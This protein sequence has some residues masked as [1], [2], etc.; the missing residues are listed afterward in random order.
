MQS[1]LYLPRIITELG[2]DLHNNVSIVLF[3]FI[4]TAMVCE[5]IQP[6]RLNAEGFSPS[7]L[8]RGLSVSATPGIPT[9]P[10]EK[11]LNDAKAA[12]EASDIRVLRIMVGWHDTEGYASLTL[13]YEPLASLGHST[14]QVVLRLSAA[15]SK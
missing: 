6:E 10:K 5:V 14:F 12:A 1:L 3:M 13:G 2:T 15:V 4:I 11:R 9:T 7:A 8:S